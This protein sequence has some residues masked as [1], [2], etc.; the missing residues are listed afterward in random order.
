MS[1]STMASDAIPTPAK[2]PEKTEKQLQQQAYYAA[3]KAAAT[4]KKTGKVVKNPAAVGKGKHIKEEEHRPEVAGKYDVMIIEAITALKER[5]GSSR[6]AMLKYI[7]ANHSEKGTNADKAKVQ[8]NKSI[9]RMLVAEQI[10][11]KLVPINGS[12]RLPKD[13]EQ[14]IYVNPR[15]G[16]SLYLQRS[17]QRSNYNSKN[18]TRQEKLQSLL[19][20]RLNLSSPSSSCSF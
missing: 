5:G 16:K 9:R 10:V 1:N 6:K 13:V 8:I 15:K 19:L 2:K 4:G 11:G 20:R 14:K 17:I 3:R 7:I 18:I 12:F